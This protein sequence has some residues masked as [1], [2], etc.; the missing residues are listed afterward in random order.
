MSRTPRASRPRW[1]V[2]RRRRAALAAAAML[3]VAGSAA[4]PA[5]ATDSPAVRTAAADPVTGQ[6]AYV[7]VGGAFGLPNALAVM[8]TR[9]DSLVDF[10]TMPQYLNGIAV[11][12]AGTRVYG[13]TQGAVVVMDP[14]TDATLGTIPVG[15]SN[16][17]IAISPSG[18]QAYVAD[19]SGTGSVHVVDTAAQTVTATIAA[20]GEGLALSPDGTRLYSTGPGGVLSVIDTATDTVVATVACGTSTGYV[21]VD[22][23]GAHAYVTDWATHSLYVVDAATDSVTATV[24]LATFVGNP[25]RVVVNPAGTTAY[26]GQGPAGEVLGI[27]LATRN[28]L[29]ILQAG[30]GILAE[31]I[32]SA[33]S[34]LYVGASDGTMNPGGSVTAFDTAGPTQSGALGLAGYPTGIALG[35]T[36]SGT[37]VSL[38]TAPTGTATQGKPVTLTA[39]VSGA[40]SGTVQFYDRTS[41]AYGPVPLGA[42]VPVTNGTATL[43]TSSLTLDI[44]SLSAAFTPAAPGL[45]RSASSV[46]SV[47]VIPAGVNVEQ[48]YN[49]TGT[50]IVIST[51]YTTGPRLLLAFV[52]SDGPAQKQS[53]SITS[54]GLDWTLVKRADNQG[55]T[56]EIWSAYASGPL[57]D[58]AVASSP[59]FDGFDQQLTVLVITGATRVGASAAAGSSTGVGHVSLTTTGAGSQVYGV[60]EDYTDAQARTVA[61][62]QRLY[63]QW[64]DTASGDTYWTQGTSGTTIPSGT[65]VTLSDT[66]PTGDTWNMAA[67][68]VLSSGS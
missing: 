2:P 12:P 38:T 61:S 49:A 42:P 36:S 1:F 60:G 22:G 51:L 29:H 3:C 20:G 32:D 14:V 25:T 26:V 31:A 13:T 54:S 21:A 67:V 17:D 47:Q 4:A 52:S 6:L 63:S 19:S 15:A 24:S 56:A 66:A 9:T 5:S 16:G 33:G 46:V 8:D 43:S 28:V 35:P 44:H 11:N 37:A 45:L 23:T 50:G 7:A 64:V 30:T 27:D 40:D 39:T 41:S 59:Q 10:H 53:A 48:A 58:Y 62:G 18:A 55:G 65:K 34:K 68:E 57:S